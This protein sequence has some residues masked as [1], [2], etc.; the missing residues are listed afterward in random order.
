MAQPA[1]AV[2]LCPIVLYE[3]RLSNNPIVVASDWATLV[4]FLTT[5]HEPSPC[6]IATCVG[7]ECPHKSKSSIQGNPMAWSPV[8][9][10][11]TRAS[12]NVRFVTALGLD[13]DHLS[14]D[15]AQRVIVALAPL[16]HCLHTTHS[17]RR[18]S[19]SF[20]AVVA[21]S[22]HV[23]AAEWP[24]LLAAAVRRLGVPADPTC[25]DLSRL[26]YRPSHPKDAPHSAAHVAGEPLDVDA[27]LSWGAANLPPPIPYTAEKAATP[28]EAAWDLDS[29]AV[30][31]AINTIAAY[32]PPESSV[33]VEGK[34]HPLALALAG[35]LRARGATREDARFILHEGFREGG[36]KNPQMRAA[37]VD[38]TWDLPE[39]ALM[40]GFT[41]ACEIL[42]VEDATE[43]GDLFV[44]VEN[45]TFLG[46]I[47]PGGRSLTAT[48]VKG[49]VKMD[50]PLI[51]ATASVNL[52]TVRD[53]LVA[54][55]R[56]KLRSDVP[57]EQI[58][59][60]ILDS[61]L[62]GE[63]LVPRV[64]HENGRVED[65][66]FSGKTKT[67]DRSAAIGCAMAM[68][69]F[70]LPSHT[71]FEAVQEIA[72]QSLF[73]MLTEGEKLESLMKKARRA[74]THALKKKD[75]NEKEQAIEKDRRWQISRLYFLRGGVL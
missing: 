16:E 13:F 69:A 3:H 47:V 32:M 70:K 28:D 66:S 46:G 42:G 35:M 24:R 61:L 10:E 51:P 29:D 26:F 63:D 67:V 74:F 4:E 71:P 5:F 45:K 50:A 14:A 57:D 11:G 44:D 65:V 22:R 18:E 60:C 21:L 55:R 9:I 7:R 8:V 52:K 30:A 19:I 39:D 41:R 56:R 62:R 2:G 72:R 36:S 34:R 23:T 37:V 31:A 73:S 53:S 40:T 64:K 12:A 1:A 75:E 59:G 48:I 25:K 49:V 27:T 20:R 43:I 33:G 58:R 17:H 68:V 6:T 15:A 38:H 54:M